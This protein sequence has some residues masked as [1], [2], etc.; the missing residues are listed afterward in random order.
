MKEA[1]R[2]R[3]HAFAT[4]THSNLRTQFRSY[5]AY[6]VY[7]RRRPLPAD[8]RT[9]CGYAQFLSRS[10]RP[11]SI[12]NYLSGVKMLHILVGHEYRFSEDINLSLVVR[13]IDRMHPHVPHRA[14]PVT[15]Y[16]LRLFFLHMDKQHSLHLTTFACSLIL[17]FNMSRLGSVLP[18][19]TKTPAHV[20]LRKECI[21]F[22]REGLLVT[23]LH[24]KT[25]QF[26]KRRL[27][28]PLPRMDSDLCPVQAYDRSLQ[29]MGSHMPEH[30]FM[31]LEGSH[32]R[33]LTKKIFIDTFRQVMLLSGDQDTIG[34]T[35]H[36]FRRGGATSAFQA[37]IPGE[38][39]QICGDW[40]SEAY[41]RYLEFSMQNKL[42]IIHKFTKYL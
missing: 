3:Q 1:N 25:I 39:I 11:Q 42:S 8:S 10:L 29:A 31:F 20:F 6:C 12:R 33:L 5:F 15:P 37:G 22:T 40:S 36:S 27:H 30:A 35:G 7:F 38:I 2:S 23:F 9:I 28:I 14:R 26:G 13:G 21:N 18:D 41:K 4:G 32:L 17:F 34:F 24:T 19:S 16:H